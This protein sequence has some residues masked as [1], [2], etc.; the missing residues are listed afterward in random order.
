MSLFE[1]EQER[2][3]F[4]PQEYW[5]VSGLFDC[6]KNI[7]DA[8]LIKINHKTLIFGLLIYSIINDCYLLRGGLFPRP[9]PEGLPVVLGAFVGFDIA[10]SFFDC[11]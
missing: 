11:V 10:I 9:P 5:D 7:I 1:R 2:D 8:N 6:D 4:K 3:A